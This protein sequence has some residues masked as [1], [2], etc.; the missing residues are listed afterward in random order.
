MKTAL[1]NW[2]RSGG[3]INTLLIALAGIMVG[4]TMQAA[5]NRFVNKESYQSHL[6]EFEKRMDSR[7]VK[8]EEV[9]TLLNNLS[10]EVARLNGW[11][12]KNRPK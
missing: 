1:I 10:V 11:L 5:D 3:W 2:A 4:M 8:D 6:R 7:D 12:E 9:R